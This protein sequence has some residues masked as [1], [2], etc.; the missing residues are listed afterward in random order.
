MSKDKYGSIQ[1][2]E[3]LQEPIRLANEVLV[4]HMLHVDPENYTVYVN[5]SDT[6][7]VYTVFVCRGHH[8]SP[9]T[10]QCNRSKLIK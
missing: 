6:G 9:T 5:E 8:V 1:I 2:E 7:E 10:V 3:E 4:M